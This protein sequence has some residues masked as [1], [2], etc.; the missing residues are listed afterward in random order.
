MTVITNWVWKTGV[1]PKE[2]EPYSHPE[3]LKAQAVAARTY[4]IK[5]LSKHG[6][7]GFQL[8][9]TTDCQVYGGYS[10]ESAA[11]NAAVNATKGLV[12]T[13]NGSPASV[14]YFSSSG[15]FTENVRNVW[16]NLTYPYL[17]SVEDKYEK[18]DSYNYS[19]TKTF[20][21]DRLTEIM[22]SKGYN[23]GNVQSVSIQS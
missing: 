8:C 16:G 7:Y 21:I 5:N 20:T 23:V 2:I 10:C 17:T 22:A 6:T 9:P 15:G 18:G 19:W 3:A 12:V 14:Y 11:S 1:V 13:Y 4:T